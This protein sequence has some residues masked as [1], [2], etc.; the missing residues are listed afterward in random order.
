MR[1]A[2]VLDESG[3]LRRIQSGLWSGHSVPQRHGRAVDTQSR[4]FGACTGEH[5][6]ALGRRSAGRQPAPA[7]RSAHRRRTRGGILHGRSRAA[8]D[9]AAARCLPAGRRVKVPA[10]GGLSGH[11]KSCRTTASLP[12][13]IVARAT[14]C[15]PTAECA[16]WSDEQRRR[17]S[18]QRLSGRRGQRLHDRR[19]GTACQGVHES[20][21]AQRRTTFQL[22]RN[23]TSD[24]E[25]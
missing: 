23:P 17:F 13:C 18:Q 6:S 8:F 12:R 14:C 16:M 15:L 1:T 7:D 24:P 4:R 5:D 19:G 3:N 25:T 11:A 21:F 20:L 9:H 2:P 10:A 22:I